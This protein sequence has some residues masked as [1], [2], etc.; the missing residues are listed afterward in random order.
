MFNLQQDR[1]KMFSRSNKITIDL[2]THRQDVYDY[3]R[4]LESKHFIPQWWKDLHG[5]VQEKD[6]FSPT[7]TMK[8]C[9]GFIDQ[10]MAGFMVPMWTDMLF[11][12]SPIGQ[13]DYRWEFSDH[14]STGVVHQSMLRG[15]FLSDREFSH[16]KIM[17]PWVIEC[18]D[19][20]IKWILQQPSWNMKGMP[21]IT[22]S[23]VVSFKHQHSCHVNI[24]ALKKDTPSKFMIEA[25]HPILQLIP[26]SNKKID[27]RCHVVSKEEYDRR[28]ASSVQ[29]SFVKKYASHIRLKDFYANFNHQ[30]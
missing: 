22:P 6:K 11:E 4:P 25:G 28:S 13:S 20:D 16:L 29:T 1:I 10:F 15:D 19:P 21:Y 7:S 3:A 12:T 23:G 27:I 2:F 24:F 14:M 17:V 18:S 26:M 5:V 8:H 9:K 30:K